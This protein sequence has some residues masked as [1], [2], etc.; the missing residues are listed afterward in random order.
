L[1]PA[2]NVVPVVSSRAL[3]RYGTRISAT[4]DAVSERLS[5]QDL[6]ELNW[7]VGVAGKDPYAEAR[8]WLIRQGLLPRA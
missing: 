8:G 6:V 4:L 2:E 1:Q 5:Q 3:T 7:R